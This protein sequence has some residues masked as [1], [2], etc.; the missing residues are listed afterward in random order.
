MAEEN[1]E[2]E[3][4]AKPTSGSDY[5]ASKIQKL[6][7]LEGVRKRPD[8]NIGDTHEHAVQDQ[9]SGRFVKLIQVYY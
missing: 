9:L 5:D 6:E 1:N 7:G 8:M 2:N 3:N 4:Q